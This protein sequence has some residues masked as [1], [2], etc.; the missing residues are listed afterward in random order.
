MS[1]EEKKTLE[2]EIGW[3][4]R[5]FMSLLKELKNL[6]EKFTKKLDTI[7]KNTTVFKNV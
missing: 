4:V 7:K 1:N 5:N 2:W 3:V 6:G